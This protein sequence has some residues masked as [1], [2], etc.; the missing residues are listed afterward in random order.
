MDKEIKRS[1]IRRRRRRMK[2]RRRRTRK[3]KSRGVRFQEEIKDE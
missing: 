2:K 1:M 3:R